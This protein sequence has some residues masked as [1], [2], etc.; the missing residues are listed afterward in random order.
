MVVTGFLTQMV[1]LSMAD[2]MVLR[3]H[4]NQVIGF[5]H[6]QLLVSSGFYS[7]LNAQNKVLLLLQVKPTGLEYPMWGPK[8]PSISEF[9][10]TR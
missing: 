7:I 5:K 2:Q 10:A 3:S 1:F 4:S 6:L 8:T 9:R